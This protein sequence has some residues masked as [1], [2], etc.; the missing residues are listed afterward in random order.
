MN[1]R[2]GLIVEFVVAR[3]PQWDMLSDDVAEDAISFSALSVSKNVC[4]EFENLFDIN[5][6]WALL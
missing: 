3:L 1:S 6:F 5:H 4:V 2:G